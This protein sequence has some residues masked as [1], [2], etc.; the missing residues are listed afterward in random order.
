MSDLKQDTERNILQAA[1]RVF[2]KKGMGGTRMQ[3][4]A[5]EAKI[6]KSLLH[7][8]Y[9]S[10]Q[11]LFEAVFKNTM[12]EFIAIISKIFNSD[13]ELK[14]KIPL[15]VETYTDYLGK[16]P[17][18][19]SFI[20]RELQSEPK[21][22]LKIVEMIE[23]KFFKFFNQVAQEVSE[24]KIKEIKPEHLFINILSLTIFPIIAKPL[25]RAALMKGD[26]EKYMQFIEERKKVVADFI[27]SAI[28]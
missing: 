19:I 27:F 12:L 2:I 18:I 10:K 15:I 20:L 6:N 13:E 7:Y 5:D 23:I 8:Y 25:I 11:L 17:Y 21:I 4:I 22:I 1:S 3:E 16:N 14:I 9:R 28:Y 24:K 26:N